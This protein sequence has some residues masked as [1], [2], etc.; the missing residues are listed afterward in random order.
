MIDF[1]TGQCYL[2]SIYAELSHKDAIVHK[3]ENCVI[4]LKINGGSMFYVLL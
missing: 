1:K 4:M 2:L 3:F